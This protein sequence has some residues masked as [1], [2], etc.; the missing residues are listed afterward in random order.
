MKKTA[1]ADWARPLFGL[2]AEIARTAR[3]T[4]GDATTLDRVAELVR[5]LPVPDWSALAEDMA[6]DM[7]DAAARELIALVDRLEKTAA[8]ALENPGFSPLAD[9]IAK[10]ERKTPVAS[11]LR[12]AVRERGQFSAGVESVRMMGS[13]QTKLEARI[14]HYREVLNSG[15]EAYVS[16]DSFIRDIRQIALEEGLDT[17][18]G[19]VLTNIAAPRRLALIYDMQNAQAAGYARWKLDNDADALAILPAWR[20]GAST[21]KN[22]RSHGEWMARWIEAGNAV[23][24]E[25]ASRTEMVALKTSRIWM[26]LSRFGTPWPPFDFGSTRELE[27]VWRDEAERLGL[28]TPDEEIAP[29]AERDFNAE[30]EASGS[31]VSAPLAREM[32]EAF[33]DQVLWKAD[34]QKFVWQGNLIQ[35]LVRDVEGYGLDRPFDNKQFKGRAVKLGSATRPAVLQATEAG[36]DLR[37]AQMVM[38]PDNVYH[39]LQRHGAGRE[40][41]PDQRDLSRLDV[42]LIPHVWRAPDRVYRDRQGIVFEKYLMGR[43]QLVGVETQRNVLYPH[44]VRVKQ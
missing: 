13:I 25:G 35:H 12:T 21:A 5:D 41:R 22:P 15:K 10:I 8:F 14:G 4:R 16:R 20:L 26:R 31:L 17:G 18:K 23:G 43:T 11:R 3:D 44:S 7:E 2:F 19:N 34:E 33:G 42:E 1:L 38:T 36:I 40:I 24:W 29:T 9:A 6:L 30:L 27:D 39:I 28:V 32:K 37:N